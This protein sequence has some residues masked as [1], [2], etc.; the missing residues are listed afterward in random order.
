MIMVAHVCARVGES[1]APNQLGTFLAALFTILY[2][3]NNK[4]LTSLA[5]A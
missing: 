2:I 5:A 1:R 4:Y 3:M